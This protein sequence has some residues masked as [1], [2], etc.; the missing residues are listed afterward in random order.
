MTCYRTKKIQLSN[1]CPSSLKKNQF[2]SFH[3]LYYFRT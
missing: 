1:A 2:L 3:L